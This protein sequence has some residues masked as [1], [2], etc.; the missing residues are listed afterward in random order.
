MATSPLNAYAQ[1]FRVGLTGLQTVT[2]LARID[3]RPLA[4][5]RIAESDTLAS[6][7][8]AFYG[9]SWGAMSAVIQRENGLSSLTVLPVGLVIIIPTPGWRVL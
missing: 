5:Y 3:P 4:H 7:A 6:I 1:T 2:T 8:V 9:E